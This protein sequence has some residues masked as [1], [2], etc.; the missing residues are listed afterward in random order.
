MQ[1]GFDF[2]FG[3]AAASFLRL[4]RSVLADKVAAP[5]CPKLAE[6]AKNL[7]NGSQISHAVHFEA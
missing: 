2:Y 6:L 1:R 5:I 4:V 3:L 7:A